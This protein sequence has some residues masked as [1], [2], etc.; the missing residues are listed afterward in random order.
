MNALLHEQ[1]GLCWAQAQESGQRE[2][3]E[4]GLQR[5]SLARGQVQA[6]SRGAKGRQQQR[7][8]ESPEEIS[9]SF[10]GMV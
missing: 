9:C 1:M 4:A 6:W 8:E 5:E 10:S 2:A 3:V 7:E